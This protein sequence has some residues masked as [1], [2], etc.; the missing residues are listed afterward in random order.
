VEILKRGDHGYLQDP[1]KNFGFERFDGLGSPDVVLIIAAFEQLSGCWNQYNL[2]EQE[3]VRI[4]SKKVVRLEFEEPNKFFIGEN[5]DSYDYSFFKV[6]TLCPYT[7]DYLNNL[8]GVKR[9]VPIFFPFAKEAI[10]EKRKKDIDIIYK[11]HIIAKPIYKDIKTISNFN[12]RLVSNSKN[13]L[14]TNFGVDYHQKIS[15]ISRS[16]VTLVHNLLYP[17]FQ[18]LKEVWKY[19]D[20]K[21]N[22]AFKCLPQP[23]SWMGFFL[24]RKNMIVPQLKSRVFEAAF[25]HSLIL[26]KKDPFNVIENFFNPEEEFI[27]F[28]EGELKEKLADI[29]QNYEKYIPMIDKAYKKAVDLYTTEA[30]F[31]QHLKNI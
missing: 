28:H 14:V 3:L 21:N 7:A 19:P 26:C 18:H 1:T 5:F 2:S 31:N 12:Y 13:K 24:N 25:S 20:W 9:R 23:S 17:T 22:L 30:F 8:Q 11:G 29:L 6:F 10:P 15:L 27:Y 16:K 4:K